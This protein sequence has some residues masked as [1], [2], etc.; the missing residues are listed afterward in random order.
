MKTQKTVEQL[1]NEIDS[2]TSDK[3]RQ[4]KTT[5]FVSAR[6]DNKINKL[7]KEL[8]LLMSEIN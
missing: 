4:I 5:G 7:K 8:D 2:L 1:S 3:N 6:T